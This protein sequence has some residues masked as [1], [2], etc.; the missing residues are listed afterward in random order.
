MRIYFFVLF[1]FFFIL[2]KSF[3]DVHKPVK[4]L[5][6]TVVSEASEVYFFFFFL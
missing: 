6:Y 1:I 5:S 2:I 3:K 4:I